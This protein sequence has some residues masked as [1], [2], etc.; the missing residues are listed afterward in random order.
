MGYQLQRTHGIYFAAAS[1]KEL[2]ALGTR[3]GD[4]I[5]IKK[6]L[7]IRSFWRNPECEYWTRH[8]SMVK[9]KAGIVSQ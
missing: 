7:L 1:A 4:M 5:C 9:G 6:G 8:G 2:E 3:L